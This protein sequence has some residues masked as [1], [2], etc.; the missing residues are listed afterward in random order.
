M[1]HALEGIRPLCHPD[2]DLGEGEA[3]TP[4]IENQLVAVKLTDRK[5][6]ETNDRT[7]VSFIREVEVL[8]V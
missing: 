5:A 2:T 8:K 1:D 3:A 6:F 7:R 4:A